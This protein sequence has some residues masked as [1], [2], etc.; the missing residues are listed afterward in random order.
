MRRCREV[1]AVDVA[2]EAQGEVEGSLDVGE[3]DREAAG[4]ALDVLAL[5][6]DAPGLLVVQLGGDAVGVVGVEEL[7]LL[8]FQLGEDTLA[9]PALAFAGGGQVPDLGA[10]GAADALLPGPVEPDGGVVALDQLGDGVDALVALD[11]SAAALGAA[12]EVGVGAAV[13]GVLRVG[14]A[15]AAVAA[16]ERPLEFPRW[17][18]QGGFRRLGPLCGSCSRS[19]PV[20]GGRECCGVGGGCRRSRCS[21]R[22][23][24]AAQRVSARRGDGSVPS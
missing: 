16:V 11:A 8:G 24:C 20:S 1:G 9:T 17:D 7:L 13:A 2:D 15:A 19:R 6:G 4:D 10:D 23:R 21:Q 3:L 18:G 12:D 22:P 5:A 14:Q